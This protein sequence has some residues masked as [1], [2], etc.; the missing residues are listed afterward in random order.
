MSAT[1]EADKLAAETKRDEVCGGYGVEKGTFRAVLRYGQRKVAGSNGVKPVEVEIKERAPGVGASQRD[2]P[3]DL[4]LRN[5]GIENADA[6]QNFERAREEQH[7]TGM[8]VEV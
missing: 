3:V 8:R 5:H 2:V 4:A 6:S 1:L 7:C